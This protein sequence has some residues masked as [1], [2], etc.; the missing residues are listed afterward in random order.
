ME[1]RYYQK[2]AAAAILSCVEQGLNPLVV[3]AT[4]TG[5]TSVAALAMKQFISWGK[6]TLFLAHRE[7]L[8]LQ[9]RQSVYDWTD[10]YPDIEMG[11]SRASRDANVVIASVQSMQNKRLHQWP[12]GQFPFLFTDEAHHATAPSYKKL[13]EHFITSSHIGLTATPDRA[14]KSSH[15]SDVYDT[16][17]YEF[18]LLRAI[19]ESYLVPM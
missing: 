18:P 2:E 5:K 3:M 7:E 8:V 11:A 12:V 14:G 13:Q 16:I 1:P 4:G 17:A 15:L 9:A 19:R 6:R 10:Y